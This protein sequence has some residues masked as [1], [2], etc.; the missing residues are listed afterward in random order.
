[1]GHYRIAGLKNQASVLSSDRN[2]I[3]S[4]FAQPTAP[5]LIIGLGVY[6]CVAT[7]TYNTIDNLCTLRIS[8]DTYLTGSSSSLGISRKASSEAKHV[9]S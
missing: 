4:H 7:G 6:P 2:L 1:M 8:I 3:T 5:H 9:K